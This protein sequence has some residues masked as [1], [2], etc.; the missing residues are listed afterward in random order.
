MTYLTSEQITEL[1]NKRAEWVNDS[2]LSDL[3]AL[4]KANNYEID[5]NMNINYNN[6]FDII[7]KKYQGDILQRA[8]WK[9][10]KKNNPNTS[11][12]SI[13]NEK[14][15]AIFKDIE[16]LNP[17]LNILLMPLIRLKK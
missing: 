13:E 4:L 3:K 10:Y 15:V 11:Y 5:I 17:K 12:G 8:E 7:Y 16:V 1:R 6:V 14:T 9:E 2:D